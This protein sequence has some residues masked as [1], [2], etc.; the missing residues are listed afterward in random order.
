[1]K[2][3]V[4]KTF[5]SFCIVLS[6]IG[7]QILPSF[8]D[9]GIGTGIDT[10]IAADTGISTDTGIELSTDYAQLQLVSD[11]AMENVYFPAN[12]GRFLASAT[13]ES[14]LKGLIINAI[15]SY[16]TTV[17]ISGLNIPYNADNLASLRSAMSATF[18]EN[19]QF[20][21]VSNGYR[22]SY[23][24]TTFKSIILSYED[25]YVITGTTT[26]NIGAIDVDVKLYNDGVNYAME[27][28]TS[29]MSD[30]EK[31]L[32]LH[33]WLV[34]ECDY[35]YENYKAGT[36][37]QDSYSA[38]GVFM[39]GSAVCNGYA[40]AYSAL[41]QKIGI[42][43]YVVTSTSM[44]HAWNLVYLNGNWYHIDATWDDP[45][46]S[47]SKQY[48]D[49]LCE[50]YVR[51][52]FFLLSDDEIKNSTNG[53]H[54]GW[55]STIPIAASSG[56]FDNYCFKNVD[57]SM[58]YYNGYWYYGTGTHI[59]KASIDKSVLQD[60]IISDSIRYFHM[61][62]SI[63][64]WSTNNKLVK[65]DAKVY[66]TSSQIMSTQTGTYNGYY[67]G[68][69]TIKRNKLKLNLYKYSSVTSTYAF[70]HL[71]IGPL[72]SISLDK[73]SYTLIGG[74]TL[75][76]NVTYNPTDTTEDKTIIWSSNNATVAT[77]SNNGAVSALTNGTATITATCGTLSA[78]CNITVGDV[79]LGDVTLDNAV[80]IFD[81]LDIQ[82]SILGTS[83]L[84]GKALT[85]ADVTRDSKV[86]IFDI[87]AIQRHIL[88]VE[89]IK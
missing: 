59:Y 38:K 28:V 70:E 77:V 68:E 89:I 85:A 6:C 80:D 23:S 21:Y 54:Y 35:D 15:E 1:M 14:D 48:E 50:G 71:S 39:K 16:S 27:S 20:F 81:I 5:I 3:K 58:N 8:A 51:H 41:M 11:G 84:T 12:N 62:G 7:I 78:T 26:P 9:T 83:V 73:T 43:S 63:M 67:I 37:P 75:Q 32:A 87:L 33:D 76:L 22:Y 79:K 55:A 52:A 66:P 13:W 60:T 64:Y 69:F 24:T 18:N 47:S 44:N 88:G 34:R 57:V 31:I 74:N 25:E 30:M 40:L 82:R 61:D 49:S 86:D 10:G 56:G 45:V 36:I 42:S 65:S 53:S 29:S 19:P 4:I 72:T 2:N 46:F 17:D